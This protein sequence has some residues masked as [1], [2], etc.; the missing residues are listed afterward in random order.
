MYVFASHGHLDAIDLVLQEVDTDLTIEAQRRAT[1]D[2][3]G[4][5]LYGTGE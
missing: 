1:G 4:N 2:I 3:A 5:H